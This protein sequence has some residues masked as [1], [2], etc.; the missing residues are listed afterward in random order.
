MSTLHHNARVVYRDAECSRMCKHSCSWRFCVSP[1]C[2][3]PTSVGPNASFGDVLGQEADM[4][5]KTA[6]VCQERSLK[7][8]MSHDV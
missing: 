8:A 5:C 7:M 3:T 1:A 2:C 4:S 6:P